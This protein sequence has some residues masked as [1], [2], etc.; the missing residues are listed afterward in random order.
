MPRTELTKIENH[1]KI[2]VILVQNANAT[3]VFSIKNGVL[4][5]GWDVILPNT[6]AMAFWMCFVHFGARA[7]GQ[8]ELNYLLFESG[9]L[10]KF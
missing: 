3:S 5:T 9:N 6:W 7:I 1:S 10:K 4:F 2:P 8:N